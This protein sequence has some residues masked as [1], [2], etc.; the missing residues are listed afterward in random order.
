[1]LSAMVRLCC[2]RIFRHVAAAVVAFTLYI[3]NTVP[4]TH[5]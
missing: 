3:D 1:M 5:T 2:G 4:F